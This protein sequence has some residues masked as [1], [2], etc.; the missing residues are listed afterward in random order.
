MLALRLKEVGRE[1]DKIPEVRRPRSLQS[2]LQYTSLHD[3][4]SSLYSFRAALSH[5]VEQKV[6]GS[7]GCL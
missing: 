3:V 4:A 6:S 2:F 7:V 5:R 1:M